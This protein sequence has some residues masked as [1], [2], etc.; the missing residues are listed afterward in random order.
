VPI[1]NT[2]IIFNNNDLANNNVITFG[3]AQNIISTCYNNTIAQSNSFTFDC[4]CSTI[5]QSNSL[6]INCQPFN[7]PC[8]LI[9]VSAP[10]GQAPFECVCSDLWTDSNNFYISC[11]TTPGSTIN[12][13]GQSILY[14]GQSSSFL[15]EFNLGG[16]S[17][18]RILSHP[19]Q[20]SRERSGGTTP[21]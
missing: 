21:G 11:T 2:L 4:G 14:F 20:R 12:A 13:I 5:S 10:A 19:H 16:I 1:Q 6:S 17:A 15:F 18:S 3:A 9:W 8:G 7:Y